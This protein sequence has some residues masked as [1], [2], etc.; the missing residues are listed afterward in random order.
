MECR[1]PYDQLQHD[2]RAV[3]DHAIAVGN[4]IV[5]GTEAG[6][7]N[8]LPGL[9][10]DVAADRGWYVFVHK[11]GEWVAFDKTW[12]RH[13]DHGFVAAIPGTSQHTPRG[14]VWVR[15]QANDDALV[16]V[17][18]VHYLTAD[19][20][21][22]ALNADLKAACRKWAS[23][24]LNDGRLP[25][26]NGDVNTDDRT[27]DVFGGTLVTV[28]DE[29]GKYPETIEN[30]SGRTIDVIARHGKTSGRFT[31]GRAYTDA[32]LKL[33][34]DHRLIEAEFSP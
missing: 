10:R 13:L 19:R 5:T 4:V 21:D 15:I 3:F 16:S 32:D 14:I 9:I 33:Y 1:D 22:A 12:G 8:P 34:G 7:K 6:Q 20:P 18:S 24:E 25:F 31:A 23:D 2:V 27:K 17:G 11:W 30:N 28:W 26:V 29:L